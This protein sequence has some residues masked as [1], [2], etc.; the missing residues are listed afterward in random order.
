ML[1][2]ALLWCI[3]LVHSAKTKVI[4]KHF[5]KS[6]GSFALHVLQ[7]TLG[8]QNVYNCREVEALAACKRVQESSFVIS[9]ARN[10]LTYYISLWAYGSE[11][12]GGFRKY[13]DSET[14]PMRKMNDNQDAER[15]QKWIQNINSPG[16]GLESLRFY[17]SFLANKTKGITQQSFRLSSSH[18]KHIQDMFINIT[19]EQL[20]VD[21]WVDQ[22]EEENDLQYCLHMLEQR[23]IA[24]VNWQALQNY[25][26]KEK[27][28]NSHHMSCEFYLD[29]KTSDVIRD[30]DVGLF[31]LF[32][33]EGC[34]SWQRRNCTFNNYDKSRNEC[35]AAPNI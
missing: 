17:H 19:L 16:L 9:N 18:A 25:L 26:K 4:Y 35:T 20:G 6:G 22:T 11:G 21:C 10:P 3:A 24:K 15:L 27:H 28:N 12:R 30:I 29:D 1:Y 32:Q 23:G 5:P 2:T 13:W 8:K 14:S 7:D 33:F 34:G 31:K